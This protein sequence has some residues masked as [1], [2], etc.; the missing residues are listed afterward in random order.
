M[1]RGLTD[2]SVTDKMSGELSGQAGEVLDEMSEEIVSEVGASIVGEIAA[3][4]AL[5]WIPGVGFGKLGFEAIIGIHLLTGRSL[6]PF[7]RVASGGGA[8]LNLVG[9]GWL[10]NLK[11]LKHSRVVGQQANKWFSS[12]INGEQ[13]AKLF[14]FVK[15]G[16]IEKARVYLKAFFQ[17]VGEIGFKVQRRVKTRK[18]VLAGSG[19]SADE[20]S[21]TIV[22]NM[23]E[24][25]GVPG[26]LES[27]KL[28]RAID[29][30]KMSKPGAV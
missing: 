15:E 1:K 26:R 6:S 19:S 7:E 24:G 22:I 4:L 8:V 17:S 5:D 28:S 13:W 11:S 3:D 2:S 16:Q 21:E 9:F 29:P 20:V 25:L 10:K 27:G 14:H 18:K 12:H 30:D 23:E